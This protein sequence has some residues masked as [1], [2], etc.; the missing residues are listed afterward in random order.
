[1]VYYHF[2]YLNRETTKVELI[3]ID[4]KDEFGDMSKVVNQN[5]ERTQKA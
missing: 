4:S 3:N 1:M 5:I 2:F